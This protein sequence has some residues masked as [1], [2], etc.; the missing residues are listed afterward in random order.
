MM[1]HLCVL[2]CRVDEADEQLTELDRLD[3]PPGRPEI[4]V[5]LDALEGQVA[6]VGQRLLGRLVELQWEEIDVSAQKSWDG[7]LR[8]G[9]WSARQPSHAPRHPAVVGVQ[10]PQSTSTLC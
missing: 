5:V 6:T 2:I 1:S 7:R 10:A 9:W 4:G 8:R 3:L